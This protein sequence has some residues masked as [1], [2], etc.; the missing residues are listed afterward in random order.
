MS[1]WKTDNFGWFLT[2]YYVLE[3]FSLLAVIE[4]KLIGP[5]GG[6]Q[7]GKKAASDE[8]GPWNDPEAY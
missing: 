4:A 7:V 2:A 1:T 5:H 3:L 6:L 8:D